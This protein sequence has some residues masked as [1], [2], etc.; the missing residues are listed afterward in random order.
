MTALSNGTFGRIG[1]DIAE[2]YLKSRGYRI[3]G[4]NYNTYHGELDVIALRR[5]TLVFV[6]VKAKSTLRYGYPWQEL[7]RHKM[8]NLRRAAAEFRKVDGS[9]KRV[10]VYLG[11]LR[12]TKKYKRI[13]FD[14]LEIIINGERAIRITHT[15]NVF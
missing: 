15:E 4:M 7:T 10:P 13:R 1:E 12:F 2:Q 5:R 14:L 3:I 9:G 6:E 11:R 8:G